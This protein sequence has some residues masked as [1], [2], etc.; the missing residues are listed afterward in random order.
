MFADGPEEKE[1][2]KLAKFLNSLDPDS[3]RTSS[4]AQAWQLEPA[5]EPQR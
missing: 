3:L 1:G 2:S 4:S 5:L